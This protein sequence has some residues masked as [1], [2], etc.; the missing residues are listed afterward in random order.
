MKHELKIEFDQ[1]RIV[2]RYAVT[3]WAR[4]LVLYAIAAVAI[5]FAC[6]FAVAVVLR[7]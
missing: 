2:T 3:M 6:G 7:G 5:G 1:R 4:T